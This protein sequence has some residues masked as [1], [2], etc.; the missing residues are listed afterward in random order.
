M[1]AS[2]AVTVAANWHIFE[3]LVDLD[4]V[5]KEPYAALAAELPTKV[6]DTTYDIDIREG[7]TFQNGDPVTADDVVFSYGACSTRPAAHCSRR[8]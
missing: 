8:T 3:G 6:D 4:P 7:A 5:T 2:G 1:I